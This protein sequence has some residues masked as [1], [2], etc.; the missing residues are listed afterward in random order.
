M[1]EGRSPAQSTP[2]GGT[3][4]VRYFAGAAEAA[5]RE[6]ERLD[7]ADLGPAA[8]A[9]AALTLGAP[10]PTPTPASAAPG[11]AGADA[12]LTVAD[13]RAALVEAHGAA[14]ERVLGRCSVLIGGVRAGDA[15]P[16]AAGAVVD[17]LPPF[18]G[19]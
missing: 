5:G 3:I 10:T 7:I 1:I 8:L 6:E 17:V 19:G 9:P 15:D 18:A 11:P 2:A 13:L 12:A 4:T 14:F 16:V